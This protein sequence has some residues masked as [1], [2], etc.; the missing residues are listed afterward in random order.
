MSIKYPHT[1]E[2]Q[3]EEAGCPDVGLAMGVARSPDGVLKKLKDKRDGLHAAIFTR[4]QLIE[5]QQR[6]GNLRLMIAS[7]IEELK[8][9]GSPHVETSQ[10]EMTLT[11]SKLWLFEVDVKIQNQLDAQ[12]RHEL[13]KK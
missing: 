6:L 10:C 4:E 5:R 13:E 8:S 7:M 1:N 2:P 3:V 11:V 12:A 9:I